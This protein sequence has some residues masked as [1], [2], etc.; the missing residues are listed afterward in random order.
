MAESDVKVLF[1]TRVRQLRK[2]RGWS[3]ENFAHEVGLDRSYMGGVER[4][5]RNVSLE[6]ICLIARALVVPP[7]EL[8]KGWDAAAD[9]RDSEK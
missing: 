9:G 3:Q 5:E 6:N 7:A 1:G 2:A 8:F 4:G